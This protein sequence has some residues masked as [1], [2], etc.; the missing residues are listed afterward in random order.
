MANDTIKIL[1]AIQASPG[2]TA[3][4]IAAVVWPYLAGD[5]LP[6]FVEDV[7]STLQELEQYGVVEFER[8]WR[9]SRNEDPFKALVEK[10]QDEF[11]VFSAFGVLVMLYFGSGERRLAAAMGAFVED[12]EID[13][14]LRRQTYILL[15]VLCN[16]HKEWPK[17]AKDIVSP[18]DIDWNWLE[19]FRD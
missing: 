14:N 9:L 13:F 18:E 10:A 16:R 1:E 4:E 15:L 5:M 19:S 3:S 11:S 6:V 8:G 17:R 2:S 12:P 7:V